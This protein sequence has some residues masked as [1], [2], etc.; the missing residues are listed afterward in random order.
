MLDGLENEIREFFLANPNSKYV[1]TDLSSYE[2]LLAHAASSY[3]HLYSSSFV[4]NGKRLLKI[5]NRNKRG[6]KFKPIDP[7]LSKYLITR[8]GNLVE[9]VD[10]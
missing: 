3:N 6:G 2:R 4:E 9:Y 1:A 7:S 8:G 10:L 5:E